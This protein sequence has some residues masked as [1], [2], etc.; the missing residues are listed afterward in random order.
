MNFENFEIEWKNAFLN[1]PPYVSVELNNN[2]V[3][4]AN[5]YNSDGNTI[6]LFRK[7]MDEYD[8]YLLRI[9][10]VELKN[11]IRIYNTWSD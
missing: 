10:E 8:S 3:I 9:A 6:K 1:K 7:G 2:T 4:W 5:W 11:V